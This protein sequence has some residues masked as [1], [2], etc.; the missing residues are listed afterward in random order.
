MGTLV[1]L[2]VLLIKDKL[3][4]DKEFRLSARYW[5]CD[6]RFGVGDDY[7]YMTIENGEVS[8]FVKG[9][10]GFDPYTI[11]V[12]G[13]E[14]FWVETL[15]DKPK[16]FYHDWFA[17]SMHHALD[18]GGDLESAYAYYYSIRRIHRC[19]ADCFNAQKLAA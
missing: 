16:P 3:N 19:M 17:A 11:N 13:S 1:D 4:C 15:Q 2:P 12:S 7:Y 10:D 6:L 14:E 8:S 9:T 18:F 5:Y